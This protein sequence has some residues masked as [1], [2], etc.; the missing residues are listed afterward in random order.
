[1]I[2]LG[3]RFQ[4]ISNLEQRIPPDA[5]QITILRSDQLST[6]QNVTQWLKAVADWIWI[7]VIVFWAAAIWI[8]PGRRRREVRAV[9][10]GIAIT[11]VL[12]LIIRSVAGHY[13]VDKVV[14]AESVKP[15]VQQVWESRPRAW[16]PLAG[17]RSASVC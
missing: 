10:W 11:G 12:L 14:A 3:E 4:F 17:T 6:A 8:V 13:I 15:A 7:L 5:G 9:G 2:Q 16:R 1:M